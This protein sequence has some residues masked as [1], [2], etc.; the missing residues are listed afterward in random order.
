MALPTLLLASSSPR[1]RYLLSLAGWTFSI[2]PAEVD[3]T[4]FP[5]EKPQPYTLRLAEA[6]ARAVLP[7]AAEN[8]LILAADTTV[9]DGDALLGK[10]A[11]ADEARQMLRR[12]RGRT[13]Q[14][15]TAVAALEPASGRLL[16]DLCSS[17]VPMR[18]YSDD[19]MEAYIA[20][21][22]PLDK[23]GAYAIQNSAFQPVASFRGCFANVMGLP[24]CHLTR[25]LKKFEVAPRQDVAQACQTALRYECS[26]YPAVLRGEDAG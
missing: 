23:A 19:E 9:A 25:M 21:G 11:G 14:V 10:P 4:P 22:D 20:S 17:Q 2:A 3:E 8:T 1:R 26:I 12:L 7:L 13:H 16:T 18:E 6:K 24:L 5:A 15:Y